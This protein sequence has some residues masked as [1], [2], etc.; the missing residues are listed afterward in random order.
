[1]MMKGDDEYDFDEEDYYGHNN[2]HNHQA[3]F[4]PAKRCNA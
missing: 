3:K 1:M 4:L 2:D